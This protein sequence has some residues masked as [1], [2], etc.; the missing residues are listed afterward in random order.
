MAKFTLLK[1]LSNG[2]DRWSIKVGV[3]RSWNVYQKSAPR[4]LSC[5]SMIL[6][7]TEVCVN[8]LGVHVIL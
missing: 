2:S 6:V 1:T 3:F 8:R 4:L 5:V 7:D